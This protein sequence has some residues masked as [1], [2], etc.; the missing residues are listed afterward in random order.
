MSSDKFIQEEFTSSHHVENESKSQNIADDKIDPNSPMPKIVNT[1]LLPKNN[2]DIVKSGLLLRDSLV[3]SSSTLPLTPTKDN[4]VNNELINSPSTFRVVRSSSFRL[5]QTSVFK[6]SPLLRTTSLQ[7]LNDENSE[8]DKSTTGTVSD[9]PGT[10]L[11]RKAKQRSS[12]FR[13]SSTMRMLPDI[14][15]SPIRR[16]SS[17]PDIATPPRFVHVNGFRIAFHFDSVVY[18]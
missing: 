15:Q 1:N 11:V 16:S 4:F 6:S 7:D 5:N 13:L 17:N 2:E 3:L 14:P 10:P 8:V 9:I 12:L 18:D